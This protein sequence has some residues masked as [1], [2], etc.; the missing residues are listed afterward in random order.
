MG[1]LL[2]GVNKRENRRKEN[3]EDY[4]PSSAETKAMKKR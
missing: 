2:S 3:L 1:K 4:S